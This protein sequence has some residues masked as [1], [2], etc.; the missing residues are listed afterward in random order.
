MARLAACP[1]R[2]RPLRWSRPRRLGPD[3]REEP[4]IGRFAASRRLLSPPGV[5]GPRT[6]AVPFGRMTPAP[7]LPNR[8]RA[9]V[10]RPTTTRATGCPK[11]DAGRS[12]EES[13]SVGCPLAIRGAGIPE[14]AT[15]EPRTPKC[16]RAGQMGYLVRQW[17]RPTKTR[18]LDRRQEARGPPPIRAPT[19]RYADPN[20]RER[21]CVPV[22]PG[23]QR[24]PLERSAICP[25][26]RRLMWENDD[27]SCRPHERKPRD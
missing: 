9:A 11:G 10:T 26:G 21:S 17:P 3:H 25:S 1:R 15:S 18:W 27:R 2:S 16:G 12:P 6:F 22:G 7:Q 8:R 19:R 13:R 24:K 23:T 14:N 5:H 4:V 20:A